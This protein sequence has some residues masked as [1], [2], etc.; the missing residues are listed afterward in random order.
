[1][2]SLHHKNE[3]KLYSLFKN[4]V[5]DDKIH[6]KFLN[7]LSLL[8]NTGARKISASEDMEVVTLMMLKHAAEEHRHAFYLKKQIQKLRVESCQTYTKTDLLAPQSSLQY[9]NR[10]D[11]HT[12][13]YLKNILGLSGSKLRF[14]AYLLV[15]YAIE[16]RA[17]QLYPIYQKVLHTA[18]SKV[19]VKSII[20]EEQGHLEEMV[21]QLKEFSSNWQEHAGKIQKIEEELFY[22]WINHLNVSVNDRN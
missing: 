6:A 16:L 2:Y 5:A 12:S 4:I 1:M 14:A 10:L 19:S 3:E 8:E 20:F 9:L 13:K 21:S 22:Q 11:M 18:L 17:D 7:T 15:T